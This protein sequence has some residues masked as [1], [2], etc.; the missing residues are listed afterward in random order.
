MS[1]Q[2]ILRNFQLLVNGGQKVRVR[3]PLVPGVNDDIANLSQIKAFV[4]RYAEGTEIDLI[5]FNKLIVEKYRKLGKRC[6]IDVED[7]GDN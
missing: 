7:K 2:P 1:N 6:R 3:T 5:P 4:E